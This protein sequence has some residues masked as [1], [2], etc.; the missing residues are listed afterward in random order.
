ME[1]RASSSTQAKACATLLGVLLACCP[2]ASALNPSL[3]INQYAHKAWTVREGF[4]TGAVNSIAQT[5]DG[6]LWLGTEFGLLRFDGVRPTPWDPPAG[7]HLP[8]SDI[9]RLLAA[10]DGRLWI[11]T[12]EGLASWKD[13]KLTSSQELAGQ[14]VQALLEDREGV[15]WAGV[16]G[17]SAGRLCAIQSGSTQ[18]YGEDGSLGRGWLTLYEDSRGYLWAGAATGLWRWKPGPPKLYP[19]PDAETIYS[20]IDGDNGALLIAMHDGIRQLNDGKTEEYPLPG[21]ARQFL[22][23]RLLPDRNGG[24]WIGTADRGVLHVHQGKTD[25]FARSD[26]L[27]SDSITRLFEDREGNIWVATTE[28]LDRFRDFAA[29]TISVKQGLS[30]AVVGSVLAARDGSVWLGTLDGLSRWKDG[31]VTIYRKGD[32]GLP[33]N[34]HS[35]FQDEG[36]RIWVSTLSGVAYFDNGRFIPVSGVPGGNVHS[37]AGDRTGNLWISH[38][39]HGLFRLLDASVVEQIPW[40][41]LGRKDSATTLL[42]DSERGGLWIGFIQGGVAYFKN[43]QVRASYAAADG[44]GEGLVAGLQL[45]RDGT[46]WAATAG[47]LSRVK[48]GRVATLTSRNGLPCENAQWVVEEDD[49]AFWLSM[50]CG[51]VRI[52]RPELDAWI[53]DPKRTIQATVFDS[54]DG[55]RSHAGPSGYSPRV[56]KTADGKL[57]FLPGDGVS[58][59]DPHHLPFN[60]LPPPVHIEQITADRKKYETSSNQRLPPLIR[61]LE[62]DYT[63]LSLVAPEKNRFRVKLEGHDR[64]WQDVGNRRQA[65]YTDLPPR[66]YRFRVAASNNSGVWNEAGDS[67]DF[68]IDPAYYQ[69]AWFK[70]SYAAAFLG[71]LWALYRLRLHQIARE[72]NAQLEARVEERTRIARELHDTLLQGFHGVMFRFQAARNML[73][74]RP[75][76]A[77]E[78]LDGALERA[79]LALSE[80]RDAIH[81]LRMSTEVTNELAQAVTALGN[82]MSHELSHELSQ[83]LSQEPAS[84]DSAHGSTHDSARFHVVVEG[85]PRDLHPILRDE[86]Y[87]IAREA[88]RNAFRHAQAHDIEAQITYNGSSFQL[89][90]RDDGKGIDPGIVAEGRA[91]HYGVPGMRER[92]RRI[93]GKLNVWTGTGAGTEIE[94]NIPGSIA[95]GTSGGGGVLGLFRKKAANG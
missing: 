58:V 75:E 5:P 15:I 93:G 73:P 28:G 7:E 62:I 36:A 66:N 19:I 55:V 50:A 56:A 65:F 90:I 27:S 59:I 24:L 10:R 79:E 30:N 71:L 63:A 89:R 37:I 84:H 16:Q 31:R 54:S 60:K 38:Q 44:L 69:T 78:A 6:Y 83:G 11:G 53:T 49:H 82:E 40:A 39:D 47:G 4:F 94:L 85:P 74:R 29:P 68:S 17:T 46:L 91:G 87:A 70:A 45:D 95:Y 57:W 33:G 35:L 72:F 52:P 48:N 67:F 22:P 80:G 92:A 9:R 86:V 32:S 88:V 42:S 51:L 81:D 12:P 18:C 3:D 41:R 26:G 64:A 2:C 43:G 8:S 1:G 61:D 14:P 13:G 21:A 23:N 25:V 76:E 34:P 20:L 77:I